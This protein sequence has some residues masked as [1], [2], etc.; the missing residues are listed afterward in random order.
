MCQGRPSLV[1]PLPSWSPQ[2]PPPIL[3]AQ[4]EPEP[5]LSFTDK[6]GI[7]QANGGKPAHGVGLSLPS[8][9]GLCNANPSTCKKRKQR[10]MP[11]HRY[12]CCLFELGIYTL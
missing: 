1:P 9:N 12:T 5:S 10:F 8:G 2:T 7:L 4:G 3:L 11:P 6:A